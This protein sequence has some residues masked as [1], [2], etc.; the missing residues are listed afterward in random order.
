MGGQSE[1]LCRRLNE[2]DAAT[3]EGLSNN[4][5]RF[6]SVVVRRRI[7]RCGM[8]FAQR[9]YDGISVFTAL[10]APEA[11]NACQLGDASRPP[12]R[13]RLDARVVQDK[14]R[15]DIVCIGDAFPPS[16][17]RTKAPKKLWVTLPGDANPEIGLGTVSPTIGGLALK[18]CDF[19]LDPRP[20]SEL[21][22][23]FGEHVANGE[24][25]P[26]ILNRVG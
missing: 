24:Q 8:P 4:A 20:S 12:A 3:Y 16:G 22:E 19:F 11:S 5:G 7:D 1:A 18:A 25:V 17:E 15:R 21:R 13:K 26:D 14:A 23:F 2:R 6:I 10:R 9:A